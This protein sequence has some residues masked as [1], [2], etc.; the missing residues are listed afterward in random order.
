M[1][2][3]VDGGFGVAVGLG[4]EVGLGVGVGVGVGTGVGVGMGVNV[5]VG[6]GGNRV[7]NT[8]WSHSDCTTVSH[9]P[10]SRSWGSMVPEAESTFHRPY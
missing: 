3:G 8:S 10:A 9:L 7:S 2:V 4:V 6:V 5:G 1:G